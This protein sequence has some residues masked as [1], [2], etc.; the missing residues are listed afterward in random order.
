MSPAAEAP[1]GR[2]LRLEHHGRHALLR[3]A[4]AATR[5]ASRFPSLEYDHGDGLLDHRR[6]RL[7][8]RRRFPRSRGTTSTAT[9]ARGGSGASGI[10][11]GE[12]VDQAPWPTLAPGRHDPSFG[13]DA[14]GELYVMSSDG[15]GLPD[16]ARSDRADGLRRRLRRPA[17]SPRCPLRRLIL[18]LSRVA[19][20]GLP[21]RTTRGKGAVGQD[22]GGVRRA[23]RSS[24]PSASTPASTRRPIERGARAPMRSVCPPGFPCV[25]K[26]WNQITVH[27][28]TQGAGQ[29]A[30]RAGQPRFPQPRALPRGGARALPAP[31]RGPCGAVRLR[32]PDHRPR[33]RRHRRSVRRPARRF[34]SALPREGDVRRRGPQRGV[35]DPDVLR[36]AARAR[37]GPR[38]Q[39]LDPD[40]ADRRPARPARAL[41]GAV[42]RGAGA[43]PPRPHL[44]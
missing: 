9:T 6:L 27:T 11:D 32:V 15:P 30:R 18:E 41:S 21:S 23:S 8:R 44:R 17:H 19:R 12:A 37:R 36:G 33:E 42:H 3:N 26:V 20:A 38:L 10:E 1:A 2:Q 7:P 43:A 13:E 5:P 22:A 35:P 24:A 16:R 34:F 4:T 40:A 28:F 14:A 25:S 39:L 31:L 29:G